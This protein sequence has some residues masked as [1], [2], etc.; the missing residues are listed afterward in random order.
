M[1]TI[2]QNE[3]LKGY[4]VFLQGKTFKIVKSDYDEP[5]TALIRVQEKILDNEVFI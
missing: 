1:K 5:I 2:S 4:F 3:G